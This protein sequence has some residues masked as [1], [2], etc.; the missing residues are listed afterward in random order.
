MRNEKAKGSWSTFIAVAFAVGVAACA[1][2]TDDEP[3]LAPKADAPK[4]EAPKVT[5]EDSTVTPKMR[6]Y[7]EIG[8]SD[9]VI[10]CR[11]GTCEP[12]Y[13]DCSMCGWWDRWVN[14]G[15][16]VST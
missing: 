16:W 12:Y 5:V 8:Y 3:P 7:C 1:A 6:W 11:S 4:E 13:S 10:D 15:C 14:G 9:N 2:E